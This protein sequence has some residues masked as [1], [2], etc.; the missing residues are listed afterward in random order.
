MT[1]NVITKTVEVEEITYTANDGK[2]FDNEMD[3]QI[4]E[5]NLKDEILEAK[6]IKLFVPLSD[7][8]SSWVGDF[9][10]YKVRLATED[11]VIDFFT[12]ANQRFSDHFYDGVKTR[13]V[14]VNDFMN[15]IRKGEV[16][17]LLLQADGEQYYLSI[18]DITCS[19]QET[20]DSYLK[21]I[22]DT[23]VL[24]E[25]MKKHIRLIPEEKTAENK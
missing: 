8:I 19:K 14:F 24:V 20:Y 12:I 21:H 6:F 11:D 18:Y 22:S 15:T 4:H 10:W 25:E 5:N 2:V 16:V 1:K 9:K 17:E 7:A 13:T 23:L 3:C